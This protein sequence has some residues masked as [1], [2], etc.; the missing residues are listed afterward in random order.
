MQVLVKMQIHRAPQI[1]FLIQTVGLGIC[2]FN[3]LPILQGR[4]SSY[5]LRQALF[6]LPCES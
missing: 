3:K 6:N 1:E 4:P 5:S 2:I